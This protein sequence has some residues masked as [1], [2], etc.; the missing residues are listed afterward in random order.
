VILITCSICKNILQIRPAWDITSKPPFQR[1]L[2]YPQK[3]WIQIRSRKGRTWCILG[4]MQKHLII[5]W[6]RG[7]TS[8]YCYVRK[9]N[10]PREKCTWIP[11]DFFVKINPV[12]PN[13]NW[14]PPLSNWFCLVSVPKSKRFTMVLG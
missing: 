5:A 3:R 2:S 12:G 11:K 10:I 6:K 8:Y 13:L 7:H 4:K 9:F 1:E 14:V